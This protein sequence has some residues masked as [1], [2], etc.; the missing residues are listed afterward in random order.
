MNPGDAEYY[1]AKLASKQK[2]LP[3]WMPTPDDLDALSESS[4]PM[5][6]K[7]QCRLLRAVRWLLEERQNG[8]Q[9]V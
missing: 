8:S 4:A 5:A 1:A 7:D 3:D 6:H 9:R 2:P